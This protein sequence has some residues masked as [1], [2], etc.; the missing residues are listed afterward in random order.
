MALLTETMLREQF[1]ESST[2]SV[3]RYEV[4][5]GTVVTP[6]ARAWLIDRRVDLVIGTKVVFATPRGG[7][8][9][10]APT[11]PRGA[12]AAPVSPPPEAEA[13]PRATGEPMRSALP[14]FIPPEHY[15]VIDGS[16]VDTKPEHLCAL[17]G[18]LLVPKN[19][20]Q[21]RFR[22][23]LDSLEADLLVAELAFTRLGLAK[24]VAE[25]E[26]VLDYVKHILRCEVLDEPFEKVS[27]FGLDDEQLRA[28][29]HHPRQY[30]GI[31]HFAAGVAD[32][33]AVVLLNQVRTRVREVELSAYEAFDAG[34]TREPT[35]PD[36][37]R[38]LNR[39]SSAVYLMML[40]AKT[41]GYQ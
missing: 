12:P 8:E 11:A 18:N 20:P 25:L 17:R 26:E 14:V 3:T 15:D 32:G 34:G 35:R 19:H 13:V 5:A 4:P 7:S 16:Q 6:S 28:H 2:P 9:A 23:R 29:S 27:L 33:E 39:L 22:G 10:S 37:I 21:I 40:K 38:A 41:G 31:P 1:G 24:G 36:I 30:Y